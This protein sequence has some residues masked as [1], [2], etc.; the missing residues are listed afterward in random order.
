MNEYDFLQTI[1][2]DLAEYYKKSV[3]QFELGFHSDA[4]V[5]LR[6]A[7]CVLVKDL[8]DFVDLPS[9]VSVNDLSTKITELKGSGKVSFY[10]V[11]VMHKIRLAVNKAAHPDEYKDENF[12]SLY[13]AVKNQFFD[14]IENVLTSIY[15]KSVPAY[16]FSFESEF[17]NLNISER[18][19]F[20]NNSDSM[21]YVAKRLLQ[22]AKEIL[23]TTR[24]GYID[25]KTQVEHDS[26]ENVEYYHNDDSS[27][28]VSI[29]FEML[30]KCDFDNA[31][32]RYEIGCLMLNDGHWLRPYTVA[33]EVK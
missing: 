6:H 30:R 25:K 8:C 29:A 2:S 15:K 3:D 22:K 21:Y 32:A 26:G 10:I 11:D 28:N 20:D 14:L 17:R 12:H 18:A 9:T 31:D 13:Q 16:T 33:S 4:L 5:N 24:A 7:I 1:S 19:L 23:T 27:K